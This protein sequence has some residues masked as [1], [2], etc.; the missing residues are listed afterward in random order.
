MGDSPHEVGTSLKH[1]ASEAA[2][3]SGAVAAQTQAAKDLPQ[4]G[5]AGALRG[6]GE[7]LGMSGKD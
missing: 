2:H 4:G 3:G 5:L 1:G 7:A 6:V